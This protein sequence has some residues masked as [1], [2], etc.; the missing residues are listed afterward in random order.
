LGNNNNLSRTTK[1]QVIYLHPFSSP[2]PGDDPVTKKGNF[3]IK[4]NIRSSTHIGP[5]LERPEIH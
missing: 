3:I 1:N 4:G 2:C 5:N